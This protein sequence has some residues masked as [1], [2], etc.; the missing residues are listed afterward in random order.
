M[1][2]HLT[3]LFAIAALVSHSQQLTIK[4]DKIQ[5]TLSFDGKVWRTIKFSNS[6]GDRVL[7]VT[8]DEFDILPMNDNKSISIADFVAVNKPKMYSLGDT[9]FLSIQYKSI[10]S[11]SSNE[12][13]PQ[14]LTIK[15]FAVKGQ[16]FISKT[17]SLTYN[18][19]TTVDRLEVE[20][21]I[22]GKKATGGGRGEPVFI[23]NSWFVGLEYP[24]SYSRHTNGNTPTSYGRY[25][26]KVGNYSYIDLEGRDV[27]PNAVQGMVRLMH[28]PGYT[29]QNS[30]GSFGIVSKKSITGF[31]D[32]SQT[33][34]QAFMKYLS[35]IWKAPRSFLHY[36]NWFD[37]QAKD[38]KGDGFINVYRT[39]KAAI[40][41]YGIKLDAMVPDNGWQDKDGIWEPSPKHFPNGDADVEILSKRLQSEGTHLGLWLSLNSYANNIDWGIKNGYAEAKRND[42]FKQYGRYYSLS[43][44]KYKEAMLKRL[45]Y[46]AK[47]ADIVYLKHDFNE[48]CDLGEGNNHPPTDRHGHEANVNAAIEILLATKKAQPAV[49]Q[50]MTNWIWFS[51]F[52]LQYADYLWM[53]AGD[54]GTNGNTPEISTKAMASTD[55]DTYIWRMWGNVT[56][57]PLVPISR[58]MT[59]GIIKTG[60]GKMENSD[61]TLQDWLE[62]VLM[63]YGRGTLLKEWYISPAAMSPD[64]WKALCT[65]HNWAKQHEKELTNTMFVGGR[66]DEGNAYGYIGWSG[67]KGVLVAR[68][69][70][71][72]TQTLIIPFNEATNFFGL[73]G[74][75]Y[76]AKVVF[77]YVNEYPSTFISGKDI[78]IILPGYATMA[79][80]LSEGKAAPLSSDLTK[81][82]FTTKKNEV[83]V[84]TSLDVPADA[85]GR[86]E[87]L[88]IGYPDLPE[89]TVD[90]KPASIKR[91]SKAEINHF[92]EY[93]K[94]GM[95]SNKAKNWNMVTINLL[96]FAGKTIQIQYN[97]SEGFESHLLVERKVTAAGFK[98]TNNTLWAITNDTRRET[99]KLF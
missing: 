75:N 95:P 47:K 92:A 74:S 89:I 35:T 40:Q 9:N 2:Y 88:L 70:G 80:E 16:P 81:I 46:L 52:W 86:C 17:I 5:R 41:P 37:A 10:P 28:F 20:R 93:A 34:E 43:A 84:N 3:L 49:V 60:S 97:R 8:S 71:A 15:Y 33:V 42:Y 90:G 69:T 22:V 12:V 98:Q 56:D 96:P 63:H 39:Y 94:E 11:S 4:N 50:N 83:A 13:I 7:D 87:L 38:L 91:T 85:K 24:A 76:H 32:T 82:N 21:F 54:D 23:D 29:A 53:L 72:V 27:E 25:Y 65:V 64:K 67:N 31:A 55:R 62:Y 6:K 14:S 30:A 57:R 59:H 58:L 48:L 51:P 66:P 79:F 18:K 26:D 78:E 19:A 44:T 45:P 68:N 73:K 1:K 36:N 61:D 99:I 77:P